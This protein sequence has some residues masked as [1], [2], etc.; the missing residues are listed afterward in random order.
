MGKSENVAFGRGSG[1]FVRDVRRKVKIWVV[2]DKIRFQVI[3]FVL[4]LQTVFI[5]SK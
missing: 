1:S 5:Y 4:Y 3:L 2:T